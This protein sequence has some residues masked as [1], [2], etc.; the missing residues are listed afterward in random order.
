MKTPSQN[1]SAKKHTNT[2]QAVSYP[3]LEETFAPQLNEPFA[4]YVRLD[5][6][7]HSRVICEELTP[8]EEAMANILM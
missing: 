2:I 8:E 3:D 5:P 4:S 7:A 6:V 1:K